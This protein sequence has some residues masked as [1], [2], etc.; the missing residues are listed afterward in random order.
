[1]YQDIIIEFSNEIDYFFN[2]FD[3]DILHRIFDIGVI[4][5]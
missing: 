5:M 1:M 3:I 4:S 2:N